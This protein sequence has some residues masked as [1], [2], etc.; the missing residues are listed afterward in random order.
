MMKTNYMINSYADLEREELR[1]KKRLKKQEE[2]LKLQLKT[3]PEELVTTGLTKIVSGIVN[4][5]A[6]KS[7]GS[8]IK[9]VGSMFGSKKEEGS[10][11]V[12]MDIIKTIVKNK[13]SN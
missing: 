1:V 3:L 8:I 5:N 4:G 6:F 9:V 13:L 10:G 12:V 2:V 7:A 11:S